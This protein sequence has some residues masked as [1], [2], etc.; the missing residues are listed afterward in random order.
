MSRGRT[1]LRAGRHGEEGKMID[2]G[3]D[4]LGSIA[5]DNPWEFLHKVRFGQPRTPMPAGRD[6]G[7]STQDAVDVL[8]YSQTLPEE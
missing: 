5:N 1:A 7:W 4:Y 6:S 3:G 2:F 8:A